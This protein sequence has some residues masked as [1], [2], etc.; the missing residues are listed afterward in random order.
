MMKSRPTLQR[1]LDFIS[2]S[3]YADTTYT[4][5]VPL[6]CG[7]LATKYRRLRAEIVNWQRRDGPFCRARVSWRAVVRW[8]VVS[9]GRASSWSGRTIWRT[10][11]TWRVSASPR[12]PRHVTRSTRPRP[13]LA[14]SRPTSRRRPCDSPDPDAA[15]TPPTSPAPRPGYERT[16]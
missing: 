8:S 1:G 6:K 12:A 13:T 4:E 3:I 9:S 5:A 7:K 14:Q 11:R 16:S 15:W 10:C 2:S